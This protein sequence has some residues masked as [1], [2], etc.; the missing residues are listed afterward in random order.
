MSERFLAYFDRAVLSPYRLAPDQFEL[1]EDEMGGHVKVRSEHYDRLPQEARW[2]RIRFGL[3]KLADN[4]ACV[5]GFIPDLAELPDREKLKWH[6]YVLPQPTFAE[7]DEAFQRWVGR[8][9]HGSWDVEDGPKP[10]IEHQLK[11]INAL[12]NAVV[13]SP[14][15]QFVANPMLTYPAAENT[16]AYN[17]AHG[18]LYRILVDAVSAD[19]LGKLA[20]KRSVILSDP[21]KRTENLKQLLPDDLVDVVWKP[22]KKC[23]DERNK[24]HANPAKAP[25]P[26]PAFDIFHKDLEAIRLGLVALKEWLERLLDVN[27]ETCLRRSEAM[28]GLFPKLL[29]PPRPEHKLAELKKCQGKMVQEVEFG[30][31]EDYAGARN[32]EGMIFHFADG[33]SMAIRIGSNA[34]NVAMDHEGLKPQEFHKD[35]MV[36]W[37]PA[38]KKQ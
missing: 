11:L 5:A 7:Q 4:T 20:A 18:E 36:F 34:E 9:L 12:T 28:E 6:S 22:I 1:Y 21:R 15:F 14:L 2:Y 24:R 19:C 25:T 23:Y 31:V 33:S 30:E 27:A 13:E 26:F 37:A 17:K 35:L 8:Y 10:Q 32:S 16:D 38:I 3:R 29:G